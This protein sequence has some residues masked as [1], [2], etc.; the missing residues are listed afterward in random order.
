MASLGGG[1]TP[2]RVNAEGLPPQARATVEAGSRAG[3]AKIGEA[4]GALKNNGG[5]E[6]KVKT[7]DGVGIGVLK[8]MLPS[9]FLTDDKG[10]VAVFN[11][12]NQ[13][14]FFDTNGKEIKIGNTI[15]VMVTENG[16]GI[17]QFDS[18][19]RM[20]PP[21]TK[22]EI[23]PELALAINSEFIQG[24]QGALGR[25]TGTRT[26]PVGEDG[27]ILGDLSKMGGG[28]TKDIFTIKGTGRTKEEKDAKAARQ[29]AR[30]LGIEGIAND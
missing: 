5:G 21:K 12:E 14:K 24:G 8:N 6:L 3:G 15:T 4:I 9:N 27:S 1:T 28:I 23:S 19:G 29:K 18:L 17:K 20:M 10:N 22:A 7:T 2:E 25:G 11:P 13:L 26:V 16:I 30:E